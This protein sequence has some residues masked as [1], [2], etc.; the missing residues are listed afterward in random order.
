MDAGDAGFGCIGGFISLILGAISVL[1]LPGTVVGF[2]LAI[3]ALALS[4]LA[5]WFH[6]YT[7]PSEHNHSPNGIGCLLVFLPLIINLG[8][9]FNFFG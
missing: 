3:I 8:I 2:I 5:F 6:L 4:G 1:L 9:V 7:L